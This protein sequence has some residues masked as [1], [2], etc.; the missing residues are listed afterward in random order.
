MADRKNVS[1]ETLTKVD[2][3]PAGVDM[4]RLTSI[5]G[6]TAFLVKDAYSKVLAKC[7]NL[8]E[9]YQGFSGLPIRISRRDK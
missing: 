4:R 6:N 3:G 1:D 7:P 2:L 5:C 8:G 9:P